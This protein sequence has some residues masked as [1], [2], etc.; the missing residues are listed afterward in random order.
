MSRAGL[1]A[2]AL[3]LALVLT[4]SGC[5]ITLFDRD[6]ESA[7]TGDAVETPASQ[8]A[9]VESEKPPLTLGWSPNLGVNPYLTR[10]LVNWVWLPL[11][12]ESL[13]EL[14]PEYEAAPLLCT[15]ATSSA[16]GR[17]WVLRLR[18]DAVFS[19]GVTMT[20]ADVIYSLELA[21]RSELYGDRLS[22]IS[23]VTQSG[24]FEV[25]LTLTR[26]MGSLPLLLDVPIIRSGSAEAPLGTGAYVLM[27]RDG[28]AWLEAVSGWRGE[29][30]GQARIALYEV[31]DTDSVRDAFEFGRIS[32]VVS[33]LNTAG[34]VNF[35]SNYEL[36]SQDSSVMQFLAFSA[37][38]ALFESAA[39]RA[40]LCRAIDRQTLVTEHFDGYGVAATLPAHPRSAAYDQALA[41]SYALDAG[42]LASAVVEAGLSGRRGSLLVCSDSSANV[43]AAEAIA[44]NLRA[45]GL[46]ISVIAVGGS[47]YRTL[48]SLGSYDLA[49]CEARLT[50]D[51]DLT[52]FFGGSL[53]AYAIQSEEAPALCAA[54]LENSGNFYDLHRLILDE[55]LLCPLLFK[56]RAVMTSRGSI[57]GLNPAPLNIFYQP[58][59]LTLAS[60]E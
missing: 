48:L 43:D 38:S 46:E 19:N 21:G 27:Q 9:P 18:E 14:T 25:T 7:S 1:R 55:G 13:F 17:T 42:A 32:L 35:H 23:A 22:C 54:A 29:S 47:N 11:I 6:T 34:A 57:A 44:A 59:K 45:T 16:D 36:W 56:T 50:A 12:Y 39:V 30:L 58:E 5:G 28:S 15:E 41:A 3:L 33:D 53:S 51:F 37:D 52:P 60:A 26:A 4:L 20:A 10:S 49:Y 2:A 8:P 24:Q 31:D 40:A